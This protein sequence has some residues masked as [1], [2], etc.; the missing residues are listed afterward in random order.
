MPAPLLTVFATAEFLRMAVSILPVA[1]LLL[2]LVFL[3][4]YKLI[5]PTSVVGSVLFGS[6]IALISLV[7]NNGLLSLLGWDP[8]IYA[9]YGAPFPEEILKAAGLVYLIR[10]RRVGFMVD[11]A[12]YGFAIGTGFAL[13]ENVYYLRAHPDLGV[14]ACVL[15]G[16]GT[17][18][19][20]G[21]TAGLFGILSAGTSERRASGWCRTF[22]PGLIVA[23]LVH[24]LFNHFLVSPV[25]SAVGLV[26]GLPLIMMIAFRQSERALRRWLGLS[27]DTD[28][29]LLLMMTTGR[30][31]QTPIGEYLA[32]LRKHFPGDVVVDLQCFIRLHVELSIRAK[33]TLL[34]R[35]AGFE[36]PADSEVGEK[37]KEIR[38]LMRSI[39]RTGR[40]A[41]APVL[42]WSE[43]DLW[44]LH[45]AKG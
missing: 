6:A 14:A 34:M 42:R 22:V 10:S 35:Q 4:S 33:G 29:E 36:V 26:V 44:Q 20:H 1:V 24:S 45:M 19:M 12:I 39:G 27:F 37:F 7:V 18:L 16:L 31:S 3:D 43:R 32:S 23:I 38:Y 15:R 11:A 21:G 41:V 30:T 25:L 17:A 28:A 2:M 13:S 8:A 5:R 9:R 40:L